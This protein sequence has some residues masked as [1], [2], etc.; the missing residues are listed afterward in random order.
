MSY[1][2][3]VLK[4]A[5]QSLYMLESNLTDSSGHGMATVP[6]GTPEYSSAPLVSGATKAL[7][8]NTGA[9][10]YYLFPYLEPGFERQAFSLET[11]FFP[12]STSQS[13]GCHNGDTDGLTWISS[14][15]YFSLHF[16]TQG[17]IRVEYRPPTT[18]SMHIVA[19]YNGEKM[20]L[21]VNGEM[22]DSRTL[23]DAQKADVYAT[24][25]IP[26]YLVTGNASSIQ[27]G[28]AT[29]YKTLSPAQIRNHYRAGKSSISMN[30]ASGLFGGVREKI[31]VETADLFLEKSFDTTAEW[32]EGFGDAL[33]SSDKITSPI[34]TSGAYVAGTWTTGIPLDS[35]GNSVNSVAVS[36][37]GKGVHTVATSLDGTTWTSHQNST[38]IAAITPG[39][40]PTGKVLRVR[41]TFTAGSYGELQSLDVLGFKTMTVTPNTRPITLPVYA[42]LYNENPVLD[43]NTTSG[44]YNANA[45]TTIGAT[46]DSQQYR[47]ISFWYYALS[48]TLTLNVTPTTFYENNVARAVRTRIGEW[49]HVVYVIPVQSTSFTITGN[50]ILMAPT[51]YENALTATQVDTLHKSYTGFPKISVDSADPTTIGSPSSKIYAYDWSITGAG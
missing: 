1:Y 17:V 18:R 50:A 44:F 25:G 19:N 3:E 28:I 26:N 13:I 37:N 10:F 8:H 15:L 49:V 36:W 27:Q 29:Y 23:T 22:V 38:R 16:A 33:I 40:D 35:G 20:E 6:V 39:Y 43:Y 2:L 5:P 4:D 24:Q 47:T 21:W 42:Y 31:N 34:D 7:R 48:G 51:L 45:V 14:A 9:Y 32:N 30:T 41:V 46:A 11:W 12:I